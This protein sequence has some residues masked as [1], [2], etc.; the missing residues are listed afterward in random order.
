MSH[1]QNVLKFAKKKCI[2]EQKPIRVLRSKEG[3]L[4][5]QPSEN[6]K[7]NGHEVVKAFDPGKISDSEEEKHLNPIE[8]FSSLSA[9]DHVI[10]NGDMEEVTSVTSRQIRTSSG[11]KFRKSDGQEWGG[12]ELKIESKVK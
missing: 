7:P 3:V 5:I 9:G 11:A 2:R 4:A 12:G 8:D 1:K 6:S 10:V